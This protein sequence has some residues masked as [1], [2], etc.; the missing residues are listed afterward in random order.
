[1]ELHDQ[2]LQAISKQDPIIVNTH[3][4]PPPGALGA[5]S[6]VPPLILAP[7]N[8]DIRYGA[9]PEYKLRSP[10][11][12]GVMA[13]RLPPPETWD[14]RHYHDDDEKYNKGEGKIT[15]KEKKELI[16]TPRS[17]YNCG[18]CWAISTASIVSDM[19][20]ARGMVNYS[21][22]L[23]TTYIL[24]TYPQSSPR[25]PGQCGGGNP[26]QV[27]EDIKKGGLASQHC[28]N[29]DWCRTNSVC[30]PKDSKDH[31]GGKEFG[32]PQEK[33]AYLNSQIPPPGCFFPENKK[34]YYV[35]DIQTA[36]PKSTDDNPRFILE[37]KH[38]I[39]E[40]GPISA[41]YIVF[42]NFPIGDYSVTKDIYF[43]NIDYS[44]SRGNTIIPYEPNFNNIL[45]GH[46][47][48][49]IGWGVENDVVF[50][51][52]KKGKVPY[53]YVRNSWGDKWGKDQGYFKIAMFPYNTKCGFDHPVQGL[54]GFIVAKANRISHGE[55][56]K[57]VPESYMK[58]DKAFFKD[59]NKGKEVTKKE[60]DHH[61][62]NDPDDDDE[63][64]DSHK[65]HDHEVSGSGKN[66][67]T[68][69]IIVGSVLG[70]L[71]FIGFLL[72]LVWYMK[73]R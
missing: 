21:P 23:S 56:T 70:G 69:W 73:R 51:P 46:A 68:I 31:V 14:W 58:G 34:L 40:Y 57:T 26:S 24:S 10:S 45:G 47:V 7:M 13:A 3:G 44:A 48:A 19:Y 42:P 18:S 11:M 20:V 54:G 33:T 72:W 22:R 4:Q 36:Y 55:I 32:S 64:D 53:W 43:E 66:L 29:Y 12:A 60:K 61:D 71:I 8:T 6:N 27:F 41:G 50:A 5:P 1:M 35:T 28:V 17:Q 25:N 65:D 39:L 2:F 59:E 37:M 52:G 67:T 49:V 15:M 9:L 16:E 38:H 30:D 62:D 63:D